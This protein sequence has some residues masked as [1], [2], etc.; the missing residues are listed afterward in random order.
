MAALVA[1]HHWEC[2]KSR[3][4]APAATAERLRPSAMN[5]PVPP[6]PSLPWHPTLLRHLR[7]APCLDNKI[8]QGTPPLPPAY[9]SCYA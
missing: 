8:P 2:Q 9:P 7:P 6:L 3:E 5:D 1:N 4:K